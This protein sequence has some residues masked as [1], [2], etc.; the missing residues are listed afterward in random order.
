MLGTPHDPKKMPTIPEDKG[1]VI[2]KPKEEKPKDT[3][4]PKEDKPKED[5]PKDTGKDKDGDKTGFTPAS[6]NQTETET[7]NPFEQARWHVQRDEGRAANTSNLTGQLVFVHA[8]GGYWVLRYA[9]LGEEE[10][11]GGSV[12]LARDF[13]MD[14]YRDGDKVTVTGEILSERGTRKL[15]GPLY[16]VHSIR[17]VERA[18]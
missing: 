14:N 18:R 4:K 1:K 9:P 8:D 12:V 13:R 11:N 15:G 7:K 16:R 2:E 5:K 10:A 17:L 6:G 3:G